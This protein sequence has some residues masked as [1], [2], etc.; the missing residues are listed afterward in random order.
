MTLNHSPSL[1]IHAEL[2]TFLLSISWQTLAFVQ[3]HKD[4]GGNVGGKADKKKPGKNLT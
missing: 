3:M 1:P 4:F 2:L